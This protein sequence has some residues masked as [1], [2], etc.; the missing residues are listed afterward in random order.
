MDENITN[1]SFAGSE[2]HNRNAGYLDGV[3]TPNKIYLADQNGISVLSNNASTND[4]PCY[5]ILDMHT[6]L[7]ILFG[8]P[9]CGKTMTL[10]RLTRYLKKEGY[11]VKPIREFRP[12]YDNNYQEL[13]DK[14]DTMINYDIGIIQDSS[15]I[16]V[17]V[18]SSHGRK[19]C[20]MLDA[21][22][23]LYYHL[24]EKDVVFSENLLK[25][26]LDLRNP[27]IWIIMIDSECSDKNI[28][29]NYVN[30]V[31]RLKTKINPRN[32]IVFMLNK[33]DKLIPVDEINM[34]K[35]KSKLYNFASVLY[36]DIFLPFKN[37]IPI[38]NWWR[39]NN[40]DFVPFHAAYCIEEKS[41]NNIYMESDD[42]FPRVLWSNLLKRIR[43]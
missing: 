16:L 4:L 25:Y 21:P 11:G 28:R 24:I 23:E 30:I 37:E 33:I 12:S 19:L 7:V 34:I 17:D 42:Y 38:T 10:V 43:G 3:N 8:P 15:P 29:L 14:F 2:M 41:G 35:E 27:K 6:P 9:S 31:K 18:I 40:F 22:S 20:Q 13:C 26:L 36:P 32:K 5:C 1:G 39:P